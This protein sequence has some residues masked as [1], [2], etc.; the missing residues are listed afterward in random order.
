[1]AVVV[2]Q[3]KEQRFKHHYE[4]VMRDS[5]TCIKT[6]FKIFIR[7]KKSKKVGITF[8]ESHKKNTSSHQ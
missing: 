7:F 3:L 1:L 5:H 8:T 2:F 6:N 4:L